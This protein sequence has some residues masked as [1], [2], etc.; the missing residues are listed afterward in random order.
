MFDPGALT[1]G[2]ARRFASYKRAN[3]IL[4]NPE[5][6][7]G[8]LNCPNRPVQIV[9]A[10]KSHPAD[11]S[12]KLLI[13]QVFNA[14]KDPDLGGRIAFVEDYDE[15]LAQYL[16]HG[17]DLWLNNPQPP[18][19]ASGTSGMKAGMNG[20]PHLSVLDGWW[21]EGYTGSNGWAFD[22]AGNGSEESDSE[23]IYTILEKKIVPLYYDKDEAGSLPGM[24]Q[25]HE[26]DD[27][28]CGSK[29]LRPQD[30][31]GVRPRFLSRGF[32][33]GEGG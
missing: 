29:I 25:C 2:F 7:K 12:G 9:F 6:L 28:E 14:A 11:D 23:E 21:I 30:G 4:K 10:G 32:K 15:E 26:G 1:I 22:G 16:V 27:K 8:I 3:L 17:V 24:G 33:A 18:F 20:V 13:Q 19:E 31:K 5:R